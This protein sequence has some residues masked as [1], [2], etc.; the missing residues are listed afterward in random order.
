MVSTGTPSLAACSA[1]LASNCALAWRLKA[2]ICSICSGVGC[3]PGS[4]FIPGGN[5]MRIGMPCGGNGM[6]P[7]GGGAAIAV[8][9]VMF[10][11]VEKR[12]SLSSS[13]LSE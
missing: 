8:D 4:I 10:R 5:G 12:E 9:V 1:I 11:G 3:W 7:G 6:P 13:G 2:L